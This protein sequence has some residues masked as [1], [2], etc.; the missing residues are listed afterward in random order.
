MPGAFQ[1][2]NGALGVPP[3]AACCAVGVGTAG[4]GGAIEG[5]ARG[6]GTT[7]GEAS[8]PVASQATTLEDFICATSRH[9]KILGQHRPQHAGERCSF[10]SNRGAARIDSA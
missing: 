8:E 1:K 10:V 5:R 2:P 9:L 6:S 7:G 3:W 4:A